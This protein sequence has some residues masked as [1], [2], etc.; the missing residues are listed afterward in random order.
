MNRV[1]YLG[2]RKSSPDSIWAAE[3]AQAALNRSAPM[4][5]GVVITLG[6]RGLIWS[7]NG[8][9]GSLPADPIDAVDTTG[10]GDAFHAPLP[11]DSPKDWTGPT[12][13]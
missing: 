4:A 8:R 5:P 13:C 2:A 12:F 1:D 11:P 3:H 10:A 7:R 6:E 9:S